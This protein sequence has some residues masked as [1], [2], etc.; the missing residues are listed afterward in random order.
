[1]RVVS[2]QEVMLGGL[3]VVSVMSLPHSSN[4]LSWPCQFT[5]LN[6]LP[7]EGSSLLEDLPHYVAICLVSCLSPLFNRELFKDVWM[8][9]ILYFQSWACCL[10][11]YRRAIKFIKFNFIC[12]GNFQ[13]SFNVCM[14]AF[15]LWRHNISAILQPFSCFRWQMTYVISLLYEA[16]KHKRKNTVFFFSNNF[17]AISFENI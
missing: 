15:F 11:H 17:Q 7:C 14:D 12:T 2:D 16:H 9:V 13:S 3:T 10:A 1:M 6:A 8:V 5:P 4:P